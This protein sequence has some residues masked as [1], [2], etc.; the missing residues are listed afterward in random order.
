M[1]K[2]EY[3]WLDGTEPTAHVR[4]KTKVVNSF[5]GS[6]EECSEWNFDGSSTNQA[7]GNNS[8]CILKPVR[9]YVNPL[10]LNSHL[11]LCEVWNVD[12]TPHPSNFR[13]LLDEIQSKHSEED[14]WVGIEQEYTL[15][16]DGRPLGWPM[17][18]EPEPQGDYYCGRNKGEHIARSHMEACIE[19]GIKISGINS[20]VM[21]GQWEYQIGADNPLRISDDLWVA[22]WLMEKICL[23]KHREVSI[24]PKPEE[25]DWNGAGAHTNFSTKAMREEGGDMVIHKAIQKL[26]QKHWDHIQVYGSGNERRLTGQHET[27]DINTFRW[28]VSDRGASVRVPEQVAK[29]GKG[30]LEDRRPSANCDP[31]LVCHK[32]I[33]TVCEER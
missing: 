32:L 18:G 11:V 2:L 15:F 21:L 29:N 28:G 31:Y 27:C 12:G 7:D 19:A 8:D 22:R 20:E 26:E 25:G 14:V 9:V 1:H 3:I 23:H 17:V 30:Y 6:L 4:S 33:E 24:D 10:E 16:K 5:K 13:Y